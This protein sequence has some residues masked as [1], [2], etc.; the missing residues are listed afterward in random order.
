MDA[1]ADKARAGLS[2]ES[3]KLTRAEKDVLGELSESTIE[4]VTETLGKYV[5][6]P[7]D[8]REFIVWKSIAQIMLQGGAIIEAGRIGY[9]VQRDA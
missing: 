7:T 8:V 3:F 2:L 9:G 1:L 4:R 6:G 5:A